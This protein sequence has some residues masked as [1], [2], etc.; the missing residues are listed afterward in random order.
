[1]VVKIKNILLT[2]DIEEFDLPLEFGKEISEEKQF[3]I[4]KDGTEKIINFLQEKNIKATFF[5]SARFAKQYPLLIKKIS[6]NHEVGLHCLK[7]SD[8]Y[9]KMDGDTAFKKIK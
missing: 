2:F 9:S 7:H 3:K 4:S 1:M 5:I 6:Y 8:N